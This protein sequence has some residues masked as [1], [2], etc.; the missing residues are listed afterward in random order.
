MWHLSTRGDRPWNR[1]VFADADRG[2]RAVCGS[3]MRE[4][5]EV[6]G[7]SLSYEA[8]APRP[9]GGRVGFSCST[10]CIIQG[11]QAR[12][13]TDRASSNVQLWQEIRGKRFEARD[14]IP[15][16]KLNAYSSLC[17]MD[18]VTQAVAASSVSVSSRCMNCWADTNS[19]RGFRSVVIITYG[20]RTYRWK[21]VGGVEGIGM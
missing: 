9:G 6:P 13:I 15:S 4:I 8:V 18:L 3:S 1:S 2:V 21:P 17:S 11:I 7:S 14:S 10:Y 16:S 19:S 12:R 20:C 5:F